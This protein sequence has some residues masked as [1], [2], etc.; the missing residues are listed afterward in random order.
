MV[1]GG[2][3]VNDPVINA[4]DIVTTFIQTTF[5]EGI[6]KA[7]YCFCALLLSSELPVAD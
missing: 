3:C 4:T 7:V 6:V 2:A 5:R 1:S